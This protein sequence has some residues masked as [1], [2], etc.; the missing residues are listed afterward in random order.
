MNVDIAVLHDALKSIVHEERRLFELLEQESQEL[1]KRNASCIMQI[2]DEKRQLV[3]RLN[4]LFSQ[5]KTVLG[6][7]SSSCGDECGTFLLAQFAGDI[8]QANRAQEECLEIYSLAAKCRTLNELNGARIELLSQHAQRSLGILK[9]R[10]LNDGVYGA[11]GITRGESQPRCV[12][13]A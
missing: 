4:L 6:A 3:H 5:Q 1:N 9:G 13:T 8:V 7:Y 11:D 10:F 2:A 12:M